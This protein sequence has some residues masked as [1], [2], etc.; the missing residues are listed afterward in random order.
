VAP[1]LVDDA[2]QLHPWVVLGA[3]ASHAATL[4]H[5]HLGGCFPVPAPIETVAVEVA[6][7][8]LASHR[9]RNETGYG[10]GNALA[11]WRRRN[12]AF[13]DNFR[14][15]C[16]FRDIYVYIER[17]D[18]SGQKLRPSGV[19]QPHQWVSFFFFGLV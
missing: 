16:R 17:T 15:R 7:A 9:N 1:L 3:M 6:A 5:R 18:A 13:W 14:F 19:W 2:H 11:T 10:Y 12:L 8:A 4:P